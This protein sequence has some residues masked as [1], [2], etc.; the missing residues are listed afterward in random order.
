MNDTI[1]LTGRVKTTVDPKRKGIFKVE[2]GEKGSGHFEDVSYVSPYGSNTQGGFIAIPEE[3]TEV[4]I[5]SPHGSTGWY[6]MGTTFAPEQKDTEGG[7]TVPDSEVSPIE[8][9]EPDLY[10]AKGRPMKYS[11]KSPNGGGLSISEEFNDE[12]INRKTEITSTV[13][14]KIT[15][16]DSPEI[17]SITIDSGNGSKIVLGNDP[18]SFTAG[19]DA[20][21]IQ[22]ES[23]GPQKYIN[24][25]SGTDIVVGN[26]GK[27]LNIINNAHGLLWGPLIDTGCVNLQSKY[28]DVNVFSKGFMG[29][30]FLQCLNPL[31]INQKIVLETRGALGGDII[32]KTNGTIKLEAG[33][34]IEM[35]APVIKTQA[36]TQTFTGANFDVASAGTVNIDGAAINLAGGFATPAPVVPTPTILTNSRRGVF[37]VTAYDFL[38]FPIIPVPY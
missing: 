31:G 27:D 16:N 29:G 38:P 14:K 30:I 13:N 24:T 6:Y 28:K 25:E 7:S 3:E 12:Y 17:D 36:A 22:V 18:Q 37:G 2:V 10:R 20:R 4:L 11:F 19:A 21:S 32:L 1:I 8:R 26:G 23:A 34:G 5:C 33:I 9:V 35:T 15:L